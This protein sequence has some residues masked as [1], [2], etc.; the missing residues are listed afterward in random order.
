MSNAICT[1]LSH[2]NEISIV[3]MPIYISSLILFRTPSKPKDVTAENGTTDSKFV[4]ANSS[5]NSIKLA[6]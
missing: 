5:V 6:F 3:L 4:L 2:R 1:Y